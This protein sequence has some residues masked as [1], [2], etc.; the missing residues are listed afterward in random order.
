MTPS[1]PL[2]PTIDANINERL[3]RS[4]QFGEDISNGVFAS[5]GLMY[6][7]S[8]DGEEAMDTSGTFF[9]LFSRSDTAELLAD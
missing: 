4:F 5:L 1:P 2:D 8:D 3:V 9:F 7:D 6:P